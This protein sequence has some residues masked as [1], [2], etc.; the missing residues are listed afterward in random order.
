LS[1]PPFPQPANFCPL[2]E[3][4]PPIRARCFSSRKTNIA[5]RQ[6]GIGSLFFTDPQ[7][8]KYYP[9]NL[10]SRAIIMPTICSLF[11]ALYLYRDLDL[12]DHG[13]TQGRPKKQQHK[14]FMQVEGLIIDL[15]HVHL[16]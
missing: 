6:R 1:A 14:G 16:G 13:S 7:L 5:F 2:W 15:P 10:I 9:S 11:H 4:L 8:L 12:V 3:R